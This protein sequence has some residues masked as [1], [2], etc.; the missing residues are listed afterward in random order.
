MKNTILIA[1]IV[2]V[3][4]GFESKKPTIEG[5]WN[6][7]VE[8]TIIRIYKT[9]T[10]WEGRT[11]ST[12][13]EG[14]KTNQLVLRGITEKDDQWEGEF[15]IPKLGVWLDATLVPAEDEMK[16]TAHTWLMSK[17]KEWKRIQ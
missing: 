17:T 3:V 1:I 11:V 8:N 16:V 6:T 5:K 15:Y 12:D 4:S 14:V 13:R 10:G 2:L 7:G 9:H